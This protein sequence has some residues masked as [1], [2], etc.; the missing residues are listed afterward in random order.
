MTISINVKI[1]D[2]L[3]MQSRIYSNK[4]PAQQFKI[5]YFIV[6][7]YGAFKDTK[8]LLFNIS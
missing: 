5:E 8:L 3:A 6:S 2:N 4:T 7:T 1:L